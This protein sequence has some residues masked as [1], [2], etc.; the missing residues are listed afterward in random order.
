MVF[1]IGELVWYKGKK[2]EIADRGIRG[3]L[4]GRYALWS[5]ENN[6]GNHKEEVD[7]WIEEKLLSEVCKNE[8]QVII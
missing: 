1:E 5:P 3:E 7:G 8:R 6:E 4:V 2:W